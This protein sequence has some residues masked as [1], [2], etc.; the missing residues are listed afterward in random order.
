MTPWRGV[1][2]EEKLL[3]NIN[4][5]KTEVSQNTPFESQWESVMNLYVP[6]NNYTLK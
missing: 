3:A 2:P 5:L 6:G 4:H 1:V